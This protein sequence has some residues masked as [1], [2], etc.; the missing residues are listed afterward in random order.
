[1][2]GA[3]YRLPPGSERLWIRARRG[4]AE[5]NGCCDR[6]T[7]SPLDIEKQRRR[8]IVASKVSILYPFV[9]MVAD[10]LV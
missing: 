9:R 7:F 2:A 4:A 10:G 8:K 5:I 1:M 6:P 3:I